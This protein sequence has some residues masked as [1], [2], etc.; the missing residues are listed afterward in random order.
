MKKRLSHRARCM[1]P[2]P[3]LKV[4]ALAKKMIKDGIEVINFGVGEPDFN[5]PEYIKIAAKQAIDDNYTR[6]TPSAGI[7]ELKE[8]IIRKFKRDNGLEYEP[9]NILVSPGAKASLI[10][11]L[12][13]I[14]DPRDEVIIPTPSWVSYESQVWLCDAH[15]EILEASMANNF[16]IT[17]EQLSARIKKLSNPKVLILNSPNNP[18]G[19]V[20]TR[21]ELEAIG[22]VCLENEILILSDEIYE[23]L[24]YDGTEHVSIASLSPELKKN[25][26]VVNGVSKA[27]AMTGWRLG[28][29]A[30]PE[31]IVSKASEIQ[32]HTTSC[33]NSITQ[34]ACVTALDEDDGSVEYM[35]KEFSQRRDYM[36]KGLNEIPE[37]H[38]MKPQGAFYIMADVSWYLKKNQ[39]GINTSEELCSYLLSTYHLALVAGSAF[40]AEG[41][42]RFSYANS[43]DNIRRGIEWFGEGLRSLISQD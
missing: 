35:R 32:S 29:M 33:V 42:V 38:C 18:T 39:R 10:N 9:K 26:V 5:T 6:Y 22:E 27:Y 17:A 30:G 15:P 25:T 24:I 3:T 2:S 14:C 12:M 19:M 16:K 28:Y 23:K 4:S 1:Q 37:V 36:F 41:F 40:Q 43:V 13:T 11:V 21:S 34:R 31:E 8:A 7:I 20:Y